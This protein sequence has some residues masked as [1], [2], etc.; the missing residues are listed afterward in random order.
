MA[1]FMVCYD[2]PYKILAANHSSSM[3]TLKLPDSMN[4]FPTFHV[5]LLKPFH[6]NDDTLFPSCA[7]PSPGPVIMENSVK[8]FEATKIVDHKRRGPGYHFLVHWKGYSPNSDTWLPGVQCRELA[9]LDRYLLANDL[10][11]DI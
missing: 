11:L 3:Y 2:G 5:S 8:E 4:V 1:K 9:A 6:P 10:G 7:Y